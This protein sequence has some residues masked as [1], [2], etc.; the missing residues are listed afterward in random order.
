MQQIALYYV[1]DIPWQMK[2][3]LQ[4]SQ[5]MWNASNASCS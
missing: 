5:L 2:N 3:R 1:T 4:K